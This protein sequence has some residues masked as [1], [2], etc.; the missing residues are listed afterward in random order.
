MTRWEC[1][2]QGTGAEVAGA[3]SEIW[4]I[5]HGE[6]EWSRS[7]RHTGR[8]DVPLT[9]SGVGEA[10]G[11]RPRLGDRRFSL[12]LS[13]PL[14]RAW[15]TCRLAGYG[16]AA[17]RT[18]DLLEWDYGA[19]EGRTAAEIRAEVPGWSLWVDGVPGGE[20]VEQVAIRARRVIDQAVQGTGDGALFAHGHVLRI[21][22]ACWVGLPPRE[23]KLLVL[24]TAAISVL[25]WENGDRVIRTW[26]LLPGAP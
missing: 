25:G 17:V 12:V 26:N 11:L 15:E 20:S 2:L 4:L 22:A 9:R 8:T 19:Y 3:Q 13:S 7:G 23:G 1:L 5:R 21:L 14:S 24:G 10:A 6:T 18:D 16:D